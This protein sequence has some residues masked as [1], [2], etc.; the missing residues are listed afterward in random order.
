MV[1]EANVCAYGTQ[2][3]D[4]AFSSQYTMLSST[5]VYSFVWSMEP[6]DCPYGT[7]I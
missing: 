7:R 6:A 2:V 5:L 4:G 1:P 3:L